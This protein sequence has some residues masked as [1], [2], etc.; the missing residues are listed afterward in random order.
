MTFLLLKRKN[1]YFEA[2]LACAVFLFSPGTNS[3]VSSNT[4]DMMSCAFMLSSMYFLFYAHPMNLNKKKLFFLA[5]AGALLGASFGFKFTAGVFIAAYGI[6][7]FFYFHS[8][9]DFI[10]GVTIFSL[11]FLAD[12]LIVDGYWLWLMWDKFGSPLFPFYNNIFKSPYYA[13]EALVDPRFLAGKTLKDFIFMPFTMI[14]TQES[15]II[16]AETRT[17][18]FAAYFASMATLFCTWKKKAGDKTKTLPFNTRLVFMLSVFCILGFVLWCAMFSLLRY[19]VYL[20]AAG[21][22]LI[23]TALHTFIRTK[24]RYF[25]ITFIAAVIMAFGM[26]LRESTPFGTRNLDILT[27]KTPYSNEFAMRHEPEKIKHNIYPEIENGATV[28][29]VEP[30]LSFLLPF[31]NQNAVYVGPLNVE[32]ERYIYLKDRVEILRLFPF[33]SIF[34][35]HNFKEAVLEQIQN[36]DGKIYVMFEDYIPDALTREPLYHYGVEMDKENCQ[37]IFNNF[38]RPVWLCEAKKI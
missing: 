19:M 11:A 3:W 31:I 18:T 20:E 24:Y 1:V 17:L 29:L 7:L 21:A 12:F 35:K 27:V 25:I 8:I 34:Y 10:K 4:G 28:I 22:L 2:F 30:T 38:S 5:L 16:E 33:E 6:M 15:F 14:Y 13:Q 26:G 23:V 36:T 9:K 37:A 32:M